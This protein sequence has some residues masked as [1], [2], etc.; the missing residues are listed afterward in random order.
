MCFLSLSCHE[1]SLVLQ[2]P[3]NWTHLQFSR[4]DMEN[5]SNQDF[6]T[7]EAGSQGLSLF[8]LWTMEF[9]NGYCNITGQDSA[10]S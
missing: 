7:K 5:L 6:D 1:P 4:T 10:V 9:P 8:L 2:Q 3:T